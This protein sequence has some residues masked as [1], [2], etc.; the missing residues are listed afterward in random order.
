MEKIDK[1]S[2]SQLG[3][4]KNGMVRDGKVNEKISLEMLSDYLKLIPIKS[5]EKYLYE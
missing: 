3:K 5:W 1:L 2:F 4:I